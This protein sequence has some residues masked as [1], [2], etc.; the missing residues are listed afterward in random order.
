MLWAIVLGLWTE[1][2]VWPEYMQ[3]VGRP[4]PRLDSGLGLCQGSCRV[5]SA[6]RRSH[7]KT[8]EV[9]VAI[10]ARLPPGVRA[11]PSGGGLRPHAAARCRSNSPGI[12]RVSPLRT[13]AL[14]DCGLSDLVRRLSR[15]VWEEFGGF[16]G[17]REPLLWQ[18]PSAGTTCATSCAIPEDMVAEIQT[19]T[20]QPV[21]SKHG[22]DFERTFLDC[23]H[24]RG[25]NFF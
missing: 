12:F 22:K 16:V 3:H 8:R 4:G 21:G 7:A 1:R 15:N 18:L 20:W 10:L 24:R 19:E 17:R 2:G 11:S 6:R 25:L 13:A 14:P 5:P 9:S 23:S